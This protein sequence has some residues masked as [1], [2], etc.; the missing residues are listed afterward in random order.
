V[1]EIGRPGVLNLNLNL[2]LFTGTGH[3]WERLGEVGSPG[4][5]VL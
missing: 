3:M 1:G 2:N 5:S 4:D